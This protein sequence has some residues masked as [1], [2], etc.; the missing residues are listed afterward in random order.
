MIFMI[1]KT[2]ILLTFLACSCANSNLLE[3]DYSSLAP[4]IKYSILGED[5]KID[6]AFIEEKQYSFIKATVNNKVA[7]LTLSSVSRDGFYRWVASDN[8]VLITKNGKLI[9]SHGLFNDFEILDADPFSHSILM[10]L[11]NPN[12]IFEHTI[13]DTYTSLESNSNSLREYREVIRSKKL[14]WTKT[15]IYTYDG[16][17]SLPLKT[18][19]FIY[20]NEDAVEIEFYYKY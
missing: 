14:A 17:L 1:K 13:E 3:L 16:L 20:P 7:I 9:R 11:S 12:A 18:K 19:Q 10:K 6:A 4:M 8:A 2:P 5:F 15:N